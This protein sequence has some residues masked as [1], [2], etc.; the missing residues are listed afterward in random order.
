M[1]IHYLVTSLESGG[2]EAAIP[3][4]VQVM[5]QA[6]HQVDI[7][8]CE[9]RDMAAA[10]L[11]DEAGFPYHLLAQRRLPKWAT[12]HR[13]AR[14]VRHK[15]PDV[16]WTSLSSATL[17]GQMVGALHRIPVVSWKHSASLRSYTRLGKQLSQLWIAD[18]PSVERYVLQAMRIPRQR[19]MTWP[20][21]QRF[22]AP[23][24][25]KRWDGS[26]PLRIGSLGRLHPVKNYDLLIDALAILVAQRPD[27]KGQLQLTIAG[28]GPD[29]QRLEQRIAQYDLDDVVHLP[30]ALDQDQVQPFLANLHLY[31][32]PSHYEGMCLAMHEAMSAGLPVI[33]T[34]VGEMAESVSRSGGGV[35]LAPD[36]APSCA[37]A[38][39]GFLDAPERLTR[40]GE[41]G[42][43]YIDR[44]YSE[45]A[46]RKAGYAVIR[47][48]ETLLR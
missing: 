35:L 42:Q 18:S 41:L 23:L 12:M 10:R 14:Y 39:G 36:I 9:P 27:L 30:G 1:R 26:G 25:A 47:R 37:A 46:F 31:T 7:V 13:Y 2:A 48:I 11:L 16:I 43:A 29:R 6:G 34:P 5:R 32:Q 40:C 17:V 24:P 8:A 20:L 15:P 21:F 28:E 38:I 45:T 19:V 44:T 4:L 33:A 3:G 22:H